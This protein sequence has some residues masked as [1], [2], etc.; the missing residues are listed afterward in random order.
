MA[1]K[2][3]AIELV[4]SGR[5]DTKL[6]RTFS[7]AEAALNRYK[8]RLTGVQ[9]E[10]KKMR[11][12]SAMMGGGLLRSVAGYAA[13]Y[14]GVTQLA[15]GIRDCIK[16]YQGQIREDNRLYQLMK[17]VNGTTRAQIVAMKEYAGALQLVTTIGDDVTERGAGQL[18]TFQLQAKSIRKLIPSLHDLAVG[19]YGVNV[20]SEQMHQSANLLGKVFTG[21][22]G[23]LRRVGITFDKNQEKVLKHGNEQ[24][25]VAMLTKVIA[26]NYGG[27]AKRLAQTDEGKIVMMRNAFGEIKEEIGGELQPVVTRLL[28]YVSKH[29]PEIQMYTRSGISGVKLLVKTLTPAFKTGV[30]WVQRL[31]NVLTPTALLIYNI[32]RY[33][34]K[35][36]SVFGPIIKGIV[37]GYIAWKVATLAVAFAHKVLALYMAGGLAVNPVMLMCMAV[38]ALIGLVYLLVKNWDKVKAALIVAWNWFTRFATEGKGRFIPI[39]GLV[40]L[41]VKN[42]DKVTAAVKGAWEWLVKVYNKIKDLGAF[43]KLFN[44]SGRKELAVTLVKSAAGSVAGKRTAASPA[45]RRA[46]ASIAGARASGG[47]VAAGRTYLVGERGPELFTPRISGRILAGV[48]GA[49]YNINFSPT[50]HVDGAS[51]DVKGDVKEALSMSMRD[52]EAIIRKV[53]NGDRR[54]E[55]RRDLS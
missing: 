19:T 33:V 23:A 18:A 40:G 46:A 14:V 42:W 51:R 25:R 8:M 55:R 11:A 48:G 5:L 45:V 29:M 15:S 31:I 41:L 21:Q 20:N 24:Q 52:L 17:N 30:D 36:W 3:R 27:L 32:G 9:A 50:I 2:K 12:G 4:L 22:A 49:S 53:A 39:I 34:A 54:D 35:N 13:A 1:E 6:S 43:G 10:Q 38:G 37:A 47:P 28:Q 16:E 44:S 26:Q 7:K